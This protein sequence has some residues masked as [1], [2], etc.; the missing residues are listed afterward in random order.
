MLFFLKI[1]TKTEKTADL[2]DSVFS[3]TLLTSLFGRVLLEI[4][5]NIL[6]HDTSEQIYISTMRN[7]SKN[8]RQIFAI[9]HFKF[10][11]MWQYKICI[12][13]Y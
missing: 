9:N 11:S 1:I 3:H 7:I 8:A 2:P 12:C 4:I 13:N 5:P 6:A 10:Q